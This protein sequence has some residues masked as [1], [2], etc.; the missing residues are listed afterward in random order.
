M[1]LD[2]NKPETWADPAL[3]SPPSFDV[4]AYQT[5]I[6]DILGLSETGMP[7]V[8]LVWAPDITK[9]YSKFYTSWIG[10]MGA[11]SEL[12]AKYKYATIQIPNT[13]DQIDIPPPR[14]I[15]EEFHHPGQ[16]TAAWEQTRFNK[17]GYE[18]RPAPPTDGYYDELLKI[19]IH[20]PKKCCKQAIKRK[21]VCWGRY[22]Q[23]DTKDLDVLRKAKAK[24]DAAPFIDVTKPL[25]EIDK[26]RVALETKNR[27]EE[28][29][30][31][32]QEKIKEFVDENALELLEASIPGIRLS[33][34]TTKFSIP[35]LM[36]TKTT[37][38]GLIVPGRT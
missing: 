27:V 36:N 38:A 25:T 23:P 3:H 9:C 12:R 1:S 30:K 20:N 6:N 15:L 29:Q 26:K 21:V 8:R 16:Y 10:L 33:D 22:R 7:V 11:N 24:R 32:I 31:L 14:W 28:Q 18:I 17:D 2:F 34:K 13:P 35:K 37:E 5:R 19:A 4:E